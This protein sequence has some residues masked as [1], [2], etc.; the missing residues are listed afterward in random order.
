MDMLSEALECV[1]M[2]GPIM[3]CSTVLKIRIN[4]DIT[5]HY[6]LKGS[7]YLEALYNFQPY[8]YFVLLALEYFTEHQIRLPLEFKFIVFF[9]AQL[10][11]NRCQE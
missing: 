1:M 6:N 2:Y 7:K 8:M 3:Y 5:S 9:N 11:V 4:L 10:K